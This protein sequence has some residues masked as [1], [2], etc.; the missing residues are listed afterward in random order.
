MILQTYQTFWIWYTVTS[1]TIYRNCTTVI[2]CKSMNYFCY[3]YFTWWA[4]DHWIFWALSYLLIGPGEEFGKLLN[5]M[6][7]RMLCLTIIDWPII[8]QNFALHLDS[9]NLRWNSVYKGK[10]IF[11]SH[12]KWRRQYLLSISVYTLLCVV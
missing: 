5:R 3:Q 4:N 10:W 7:M 2:Y 9:T 12:R 6:R 1:L 11:Y 8:S